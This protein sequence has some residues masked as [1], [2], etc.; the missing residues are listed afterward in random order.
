MKA[1]LVFT[2]ALALLFAACGTDS[3]PDIRYTNNHN[4]EISFRTAEQEYHLYRLGKKN[5]PNSSMRLSADVRGRSTIL[6]IDQPLITWEYNNNDYNDIIFEKYN[7]RLIIEN[8]TTETIIIKEKFDLLSGVYEE[9]D[10][11]W[12]LIGEEL[13]EIIIPPGSD[14]VY[15]MLHTRRPVWKITPETIDITLEDNEG[16][17]FMAGKD[18]LDITKT[19][20]LIIRP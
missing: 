7:I 6:K 20:T 5:E 9:D 11:D 8:H 19:Y 15:A 1:I 14:V 12:I 4:A 2:V 3:Y 16:K 18:Q 13:N 10:P 17:E